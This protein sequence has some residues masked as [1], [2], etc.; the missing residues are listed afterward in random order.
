MT[1]TARR[2]DLSR[3]PAQLAWA[4]AASLVLGHALPAT[5]ALGDGFKVGAGR[6]KLG[7]ELSG[8]YDSMAA[9][10][11]VGTTDN[12]TTQAPGDGI[13][14]VR[15]VFAFDL[16]SDS[17]K[18]NVSGGLDYNQ[19]M[20]LVANMSAFS[21]VG[22]NLNGALNYTSGQYGIDVSEILNRSDRVNNPLFAV[23]VLG[24][25]SLTKARGW[26]KPGGGAIE[27]GG[28]YELGRDVYTAQVTTSGDETIDNCSENSCNP[29][30][31]AA[32]NA[33]LHRVGVDAKWRFLPKTGLTLEANY[34]FKSYEGSTNL[35]ANAPTSAQPIRV[36]A[37]FG[38]LLSTR[39]SFSLK[40]GYSG[41]LFT[42]ANESLHT[43]AGQAEFGYRISD[44]LTTRVGF[45]RLNEPVAGPFGYF[46]DNRVYGE[47]KGQFNR[48]VLTGLVSVDLI[49]FGLTANRDDTNVNM[50][51]SGDYN[52]LEWLRITARA[53]LASRSSTGSSVAVAY[54]D[55]NRWEMAVGAAALF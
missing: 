36:L 28:Y 16:P 44:T 52:V 7:A 53:G 25:S 18:V 49:T 29:A 9:A 6:L 55:F 14:L 17:L 5:A 50:V 1:D 10:G 3:G 19:Y 42:G 12:G 23:G 24:L 35:G 20:S 11:L 54:A 39:Y 33:W 51:V 22:L 26:Y 27:V 40:A 38:T 45:M 48:L 37:G 43:F 41:I 8:R 31:A 34:G 15:G 47:V 32:Y 2:Q 21:F 4:L 46:T 30:L 13:G